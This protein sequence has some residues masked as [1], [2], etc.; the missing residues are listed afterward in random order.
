MVQIS[1]MA[2]ELDWLK[3]A[4]V[5]SSKLQA[6]EKFQIPKSKSQTNP[7]TQTKRGL[8]GRCC[9]EIDDWIFSGAWSLEL[10]AS[11]QTSGYSG[12]DFARLPKQAPFH[13]TGDDQRLAHDMTRQRIGRDKY[14]GM[15]NILRA[16]ELGQGHSRGD[17][18]DGG[19]L[20][21]FGGIAW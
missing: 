18:A 14:R 21:E 5:P 8:P 15:G 12:V 11:A 10:G 6:P 2:R 4:V 20:G 19:P 17:F 9:L 3:R 16:C 13:P 7:K 1:R